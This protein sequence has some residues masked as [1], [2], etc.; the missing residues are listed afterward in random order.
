MNPELKAKWIAALRSGEYEQ[1]TGALCR[2]GEDDG[3]PRYC[4]LGVLL[5]VLGVPSEQIELRR[6]YQDED[7]FYN[8]WGA[9]SEGQTDKY[10]VHN[11]TT[12]MDMNDDDQQS[13]AQI[14]DYIEENL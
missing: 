4:C 2:I 3:K 7:G 12:L 5:E 1:T 13:F 8:R 9:L 10:G 14:A 11:Q 6:A